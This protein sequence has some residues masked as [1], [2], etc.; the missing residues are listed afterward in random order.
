[1]FDDKDF[2]FEEI[3][4]EYSKQNEIQN[5]GKTLGKGAFGVVKEIK[6]NDRKYAGKLS[7]VDSNEEEEENI[8]NLRGTNIIKIEKIC[9]SVNR[10][11]KNYR[12]IIME[13][14]ILN[15]LGKLN[16]YFH[17]HN[18]LKL[19]YSNCFDEVISDTVLRFFSMQIIKGLQIIHSLGLIHFD[20]KLENILILNNLI[21][22]IS[23]FS[24]LKKVDENI[25]STKIPGG[26]SNYLSPEY[27]LDKKVNGIIAKKQDYFA[28]GYCLFLLKY[29]S[30]VPI[31][32]DDETKNYKLDFVINF[33]VKRINFLK[34]QKLSDNDFINFIIGLIQLKVEKRS[35]ME[36]I[37]RSKWLTKNLDCID[38]IVNDYD[39]DNEKLLVELQK[40]DFIKQKNEFF[41]SNTSDKKIEKTID[42]INCNKPTKRNKKKNF[43]FKKK[44]ITIQ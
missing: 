15:D 32:K 13:R 10:H 35:N 30:G 22:K 42:D 44:A 27:F 33:I 28:L 4:K 39:N 21:L 43:K 19:I 7:V 6:V 8:K 1:M 3:F 14:A 20:I 37:I 23:D 40:Q 2:Y 26:T 41:E 5:I 17:D 36:Q 24:I 9:K 16:K 11:G 25:I 29:G 12:L 38:K 31:Y 34:S 18:L